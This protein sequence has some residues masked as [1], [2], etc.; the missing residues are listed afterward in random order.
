M[1]RTAI[2][3]QVNRVLNSRTFA[4]KG[5][6]RK[7]LEVLY[8]NMDADVAL[9]PDQ[10]IKELWPAEVK[11][12]R[13]ADVATEVNRLRHALDSYYEEDGA[14]DPITI[15]LPNRS[16]GSSDGAHETRWIAAK[17][18]DGAEPSGAGG[19]GR[20]TV[21][22]GKKRKI[23]AAVAVLAVV[24]ISAYA[25]VRAFSGHPQPQFGRMD[26]TALRIFDATGK[27]LWSKSF[28]DG[29][30]P[31]WY[32]EGKIWGRHIWFADLE[33][34]G[35]TSVLFS[36]S[37]AGAALK[38][39]SSTLICYSDRGT[40]KWRWAPGK[41]LPELKGSPATYMVHALEILKATE[42]S[43]ARIVVASQHTPWWPA[44]IA[45][46]DTKGKLLSE[47]W[48]SGALTHLALAD[49]DGDGRQEILAAGIANGYDHQA[50]LVVLDPDRVYGASSEV[51]PEFQI[52][53]MGAAR[54]RLI[55]LFP[56]SDLNRALHQ[57]NSAIEPTFESGVVRLTVTECIM[58]PIYSCPIWYEFDRKFRLI[59]AYA[60]GD[61]FRS[62]HNRFY[63]AGQ[64]AHTLSAE[65]Q[66]GFQKVRCL[67]GCKSEYV[68]VGQLVP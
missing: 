22:P 24:G 60:G 68:P 40:E 43:P 34:E 9:K 23:A 54:E 32:Y 52:H 1:D 63:Q 29:F 47:Y 39:I 64:G 46:L 28:P 55:L 53:G 15:Y 50:T 16:P 59:A 19:V 51:R 49:L 6:L 5:Q 27:E 56:R 26:G 11:T 25:L 61:E 65:E 31:D 18:R 42:K 36:Y 44:Q 37:P 7:L 48:H 8:R 17:L 21:W 3:E 2:G 12:K 33:G 66:A 30:G 10:V 45:I 20:E 62:A 41:D 4:N 35:R 14:D 67:V 57:Y 38:P 58:P 13:S